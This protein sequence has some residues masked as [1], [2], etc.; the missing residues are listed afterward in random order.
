[1]SVKKT[2][3]MGRKLKSKNLLGR[4]LSSQ[5]WWQK[6]LK[7]SLVMWRNMRRSKLE[8]KG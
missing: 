8:G 5:P 6:R 3:I 7:M 4:S 2:G 1:L